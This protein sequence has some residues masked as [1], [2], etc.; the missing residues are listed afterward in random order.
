MFA[1]LDLLAPGV[2]TIF[3]IP[4]EMTSEMTSNAGEAQIREVNTESIDFK[5]LMKS[6]LVMSPLLF[7][8]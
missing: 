3:D 4:S 2:P 1:Q 8:V 7:K 5:I 6:I